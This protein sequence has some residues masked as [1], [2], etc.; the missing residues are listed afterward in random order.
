MDAIMQEIGKLTDECQDII[1][2]K[3]LS[4]EDLRMEELA[5]LQRQDGW[6]IF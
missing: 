5:N 3:G 2:D 6:P 1:D 4:F